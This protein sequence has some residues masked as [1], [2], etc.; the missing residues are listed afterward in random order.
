MLEQVWSMEALPWIGLGCD[1]LRL[2]YRTLVADLLD[3]VTCKWGL[4]GFAFFWHIPWMLNQ[5]GILG[6][7]RPDQHLELFV[8]FSRSFQSIFCG[9]WQN[10]IL[11]VRVTNI[12]ECRQ[13]VLNLNDLGLG[14][15]CTS[16]G[17]HMN[18][19]TKGLPAEHCILMINVIHFFVSPFNVVADR[20]KTQHCVV[21]SGMVHLWSTQRS[22][23]WAPR[24]V[25]YFLESWGCDRWWH[26]PPIGWPPPQRPEGQAGIGTCRGKN[27]YELL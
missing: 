21:F 23:A 9:V 17:T 12:R 14:G 5:T 18:V 13:D 20:R 24:H 1:P 2:G 19:R 3:P 15:R 22:W 11:L 16:S 25:E 4:P 27:Y 26:S 10:I 6:I 8:V 7:F